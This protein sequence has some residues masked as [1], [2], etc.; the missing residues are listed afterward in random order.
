VI[1]IEHFVNLGSIFDQLFS[2]SLAWPAVI[3]IQSLFGVVMHPTFLV[4]D[5]AHFEVSY[6][7]N[8]WMRPGLWS[9]DPDGQRQA[10]RAAFTD[11]TMAL[12][13][14]GAEVETL[15][16]APGAPDLVFPANAGVVLDGRAV[17]ARFRHPE[18]QVE[19][20]VF[21]AALEDLRDRGVFTQVVSLPDGC[22]QEGA[23][24]FIWDASRGL[25]WAGYGP[26]SNHAGMT[27]VAD[28]F[29]KPIVALELATQQFYHLDTCFCPLPGG[30][31]LYYP[32]AFTPAAQAAIRDHVAPHL[33]IEASDEDAARFCVNA[34]AF[35][36]TIIMAEAA[37]DLRKRLTDRGYRLIEVNLAPFILSG[38]GA[39]CMTLRLD[40]ASI[41]TL[42]PAV[43]EPAE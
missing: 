1:Q 24:D 17:L 35:D 18:R 34:V 7:I 3:L 37:D 4:V 2:Y 30:E 26:R 13:R 22:L 41:S 33:L 20:P 23:G 39:Y 42:T 14:A 5:P 8:P 32:P 21:R 43:S 25:F 9:A 28:V 15:P 31:V 16:G 40:R 12:K 38:G 27:A 10:A 11:L 19:E 36:Q 6:A 29:G